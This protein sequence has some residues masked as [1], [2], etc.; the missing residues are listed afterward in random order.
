MDVCFTI[1]IDFGLTFCLLDPGRFEVELLFVGWWDIGLFG[2]PCE[3]ESFGNMFG[4]DFRDLC[5]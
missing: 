1:F 2:V 5:D 4:L 3:S